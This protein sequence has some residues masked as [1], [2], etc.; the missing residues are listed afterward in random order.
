MQPDGDAREFAY[1]DTT[2]GR[3]LVSDANELDLFREQSPPFSGT[4]PTSGM[5][6]DGVAYELPPLVPL[7][8]DSGSSSLPTPRASASRTG[9]SAVDQSTSSPSLD[10]ALELVR[11]ERPRE[12]AS[13]EEMP[14]SW[15]LLKTPT[16]QLAVNG[17][18]QHPDKRRGGGHGPTLADE[19]EHLLP[20]PQVADVTGGHKTRSGKRSKELLPPGVAEALSL[21]PTP[22]ASDAEKM[23]MS[24]SRGNPTLRGALHLLPTPAAHDSGNTPE[25]HLRKKPGREVVTSLQVLV[26]H[27][28]LS[29][30]GRIVPPSSDGKES[31]D[32]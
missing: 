27:D 28:L 1:L 32:A 17:G 18:S 3:W 16:S 14:A 7:T 10:Q 6:R 20:T 29:T 26:D 9:R 5:T 11:G 24:Y 23:S 4:W 31:S 25:N 21:L 13:D 22:L 30:G 19:V 15:R 8:A 2:S 12:F